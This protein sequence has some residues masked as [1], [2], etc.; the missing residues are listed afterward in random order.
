MLP[1]NLSDNIISL[2]PQKDRL[3]L[4]CTFRIFFD[5]S[6]DLKFTPKFYLSVINSKAKLSY[7]MAQR[8]LDEENIQSEDLWENDYYNINGLKPID[9]NTFEKIVDS[10]KNLY[11]LTKLVRC[12]RIDSGSL[13]IEN[14]EINFA[15]N[16]ENKPINFYLKTKLSTHQLVEE[17]MLIANKLS[18]EFVYSNIE[19]FALIRK[20]PL[21][22]ETKYQDMQ[23]YF[24]NNK[25]NIDFEDT[26]ELNE[27]LAKLEKQDKNKYIVSYFV[28]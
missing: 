7:E 22:N 11:K 25:I 14:Q 15:I 6:L 2:L 28:K 1:R 20:H 10:L 26:Q 27:M 18:A 12:Q 16:E 8:I 4:S 3:A 5:G 13:I 24:K 19:N 9:K 21:L 17:L 23:R